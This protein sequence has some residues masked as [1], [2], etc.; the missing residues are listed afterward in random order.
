MNVLMVLLFCTRDAHFRAVI[1]LVACAVSLSNFE[2]AFHPYAIFC[3]LSAPLS[4]VTACQTL[5][6]QTLAGL[7][8]QFFLQTS[9]FV[10]TLRCSPSLLQ[11]SM[12][13]KQGRQ[14]SSCCAGVSCVQS[15]PLSLTPTIPQ[16]R[17]SSLHRPDATKH[18]R[19]VDESVTT[20]SLDRPR[21]FEGHLLRCLALPCQAD[22]S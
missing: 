4:I 13:P 11:P 22:S 6:C 3:L 5:A 2:L 21:S 17:Q 15:A 18:Q 9:A 1:I 19:N 8:F 12:S 14:C 16:P 10:P 20:A 7:N